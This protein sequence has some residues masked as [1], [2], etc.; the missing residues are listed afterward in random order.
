MVVYAGWQLDVKIGTTLASVTGSSPSAA[1]VDGIQKVDYTYDDKLESHE[2][3]G[4]RTV[5]GITEGVIDISG[6]I[7]RYW[8]GSG[9]EMWTRGANETGSLTNSSDKGESRWTFRSFHSKA[10]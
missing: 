3:T 1:S 10:R 2:A 8:T 4:Q 9:A 5:Y 7:D 6:K